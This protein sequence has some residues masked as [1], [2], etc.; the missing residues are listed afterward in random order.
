MCGHWNCLRFVCKFPIFQTVTGQT[1]LKVI[2]IRVPF[3]ASCFVETLRSLGLQW[4]FSTIASALLAFVIT[5]CALAIIFSASSSLPS[6]VW[7][8]CS[9]TWTLYHF[10]VIYYSALYC[11][12]IGTVQGLFCKFPS[13][14]NR[15]WRDLFF[16]SPY[17]FLLFSKDY[18]VGVTV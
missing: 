13:L 7:G 8:D 14:W 11:V 15:C 16:F 5:W 12:Y 17:I 9:E 6:R 10:I 3:W 1:F 18:L 4:R 2:L